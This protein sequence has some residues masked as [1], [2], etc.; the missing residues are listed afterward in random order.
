MPRR[1]VVSVAEHQTRT[2]ATLQ[3]SVEH[4]AKR[5]GWLCYHQ[6]VA[7]KSPSGLP[8]L[9]LVRAPRVIFAELKGPKGVVSAAQRRWLDE[10]VGCPGVESYLW[11]YDEWE[12]EEIARTLIGAGR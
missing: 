4:E 12:S 11:G 2:E 1:A 9:I 5:W 7:W 10:L 8:D 3:A 6:R